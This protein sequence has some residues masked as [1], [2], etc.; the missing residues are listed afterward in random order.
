MNLKNLKIDLNLI[1]FNFDKFWD[2]FS[3]DYKKLYDHKQKKG[4]INEAL[5]RIEKHGTKEDNQNFI[6]SFANKFP[7]EKEFLDK[8]I[9]EKIATQESVTPESVLKLFFQENFPG[10]Y[11]N[12]IDKKN[13]YYDTE[14]KK[15]KE[16][17]RIDLYYE[18][19]NTKV[20]IKQN[21]VELY[22]KHK[23]SIHF[24]N[25]IKE[26]MQELPAWD[27]K[28][29]Y[30]KKFIDLFDITENIENINRREFTTPPK[31]RNLNDKR[32]KRYFIQLGNLNFLS[33]KSP[34]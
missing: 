14:T 16:L 8:I 10:L 7:E 11:Y 23:G 2:K 33:D 1:E 22:L 17:S 3:Q 27:K 26:I 21:F 32:S 29:D 20:N 34:S 12:E 30:I 6:F 9:K 13:Y 15:I 28:T 19:F 31:Q 18:F 24:Y 25:P 5:N 4:L